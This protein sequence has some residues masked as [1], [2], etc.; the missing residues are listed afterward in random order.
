MGKLQHKLKSE[1]RT[2]K[3]AKNTIW[4]MWGRGY[5]WTTVMVGD[6]RLASKLH[7][8]MSSPGVEAYG[9]RSR[10]PGWRRD[11]HRRLS[12]G[13]MFLA[14]SSALA[15]TTFILLLPFLPGRLLPWRWKL[16]PGVKR[17]LKWGGGAGSA[18][19]SGQ[20]WHSDQTAQR[21]HSGGRSLT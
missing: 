21:Q 16:W 6:W 4:R 18:A 10:R 8:R 15:T 9:R 7:G 12:P 2:H 19:S 20:P 1:V 5:A 17:H 14:S 11:S 13:T 3:I